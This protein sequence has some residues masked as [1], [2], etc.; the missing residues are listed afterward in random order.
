MSMAIFSPLSEVISA[1]GID[2]IGLGELLAFGTSK[3]IIHQI[4]FRK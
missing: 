1:S 2:V 4:L 3:E